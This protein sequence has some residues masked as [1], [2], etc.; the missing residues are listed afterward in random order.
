MDRLATHPARGIELLPSNGIAALDHR[1]VELHAS[2]CPTPR[3][4][5]TVARPRR[6]AAQR[7]PGGQPRERVASGR[8]RCVRAR[9]ARAAG[10]IKLARGYRREPDLR[11]L[12]AVYR[13][14]A[15]MDADHG[16]GEQLRPL[17]TF[18]NAYALRRLRHHRLLCR[19]IGL[20]RVRSAVPGRGYGRRRC[21]IAR[22]EIRGGRNV[23]RRSARSR[24]E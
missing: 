18:C 10:L 2:R 19:M 15:I 3:R 9:V 20:A 14:V 22:W 16:A 21:A 23:H 7:L 5:P 12:G 1:A 6:L 17:R 24:E 4:N 8:P 11:P 13:P